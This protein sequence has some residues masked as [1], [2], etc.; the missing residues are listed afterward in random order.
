MRPTLALMLLLPALSRAAAPAPLS[1]AAAAGLSPTDTPAP[2]PDA[3]MR[4]PMESLRWQP[5]PKHGALQ[6]EVLQLGTRED[7]PEVRISVSDPAASTSTARPFD[8]SFAGAWYLGSQALPPALRE[9]DLLFILAGDGQD[10]YLALTWS[11]GRVLVALDEFSKERPEVLQGK[12]AQYLL[13]NV[14]DPDTFGSNIYRALP[15]K[16]YECV[17]RCEPFAQRFDALN[18]YLRAHDAF[19]DGQSVSPCGPDHP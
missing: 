7:G 14:L 4:Q 1:P 3:R 15:G 13:L 5:D 9:H 12:D 16:A 6:V 19:I 18:Q 8:Q 11:D 10:H 17:L 2:T